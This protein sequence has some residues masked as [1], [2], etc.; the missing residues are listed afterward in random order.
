MNVWW[1]SEN[2]EHHLP[3]TVITWRQVRE[4]N[5]NAANSTDYDTILFILK[6][7]GHSV[8]YIA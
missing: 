5:M 7:S 3:V 2:T 6:S 1:V 8:L 4:M